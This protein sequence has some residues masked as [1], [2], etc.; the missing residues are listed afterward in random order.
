MNLSG[1]ERVNTELS[2][3]DR[4]RIV[5]LTMI[6]KTETSK[7]HPIISEKLEPLIG[8]HGKSSGAQFRDLVSYMR[9]IMH[10]PVGSG[11]EGYFWAKN[12]GEL[13][14]TKEHIKQRGTK[15]WEVLA[16]LDKAFPDEA[17]GDLQ[18]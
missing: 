15:L 5:N 1:F 14:S 3:E 4:Y 7:E 11:G 2:F 13:E 6:L 9:A 8:L 17:Q 10:L 16:G 12:R 18:L